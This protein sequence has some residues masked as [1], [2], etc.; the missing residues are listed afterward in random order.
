[1]SLD[2]FVDARLAY[3]RKMGE[4]PWERLAHD[5]RVR[6]QLIRGRVTRRHAHLLVRLEGAKDEILATL[7][8]FHDRHVAVR[9]QR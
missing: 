7:N 2:D 9:A 6:V 3:R 5:A 4:S 1:M 8:A